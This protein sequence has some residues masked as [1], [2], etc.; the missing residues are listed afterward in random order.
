MPTATA[1]GSETN[2]SAVTFGSL[3][4]LRATH[5]SGKLVIH[6]VS[7]PDTSYDITIYRTTNTGSLELAYKLDAEWVI[8]CIFKGY[9]DDYRKNGDYLFRIGDDDM[10][11]G[12]QYKQVTLFWITPANPTVRVNSS[13][14]FRANAMY[15]DGSTEDVTSKCKWT[16]S[17]ED[18]AGLSGQNTSNVTVTGIIPGTSTIRAEYIG[19][20]NI[21]NIKV[22]SAV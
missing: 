21:T 2:P 20:S 12:E 17:K 3:P 13:I 1:V 19:Y 15:I 10:V 7:A 22:E 16:T 4:G 6:P 18:V 9:V 8:P 14:N 5:H 11:E